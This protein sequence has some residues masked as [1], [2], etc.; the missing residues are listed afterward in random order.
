MSNTV[1][2]K[3]DEILRVVAALKATEAAEGLAP[4]GWQPGKSLYDQPRP[5][6][7][8]VFQAQDPAAWFLKARDDG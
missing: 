1:A 4:E 2:Q 8:S 5:T 6:L 3:R 7:D